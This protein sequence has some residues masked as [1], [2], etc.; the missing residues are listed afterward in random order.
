MLTLSAPRRRLGNRTAD[1]KF[2]KTTTFRRRAH[3][4]LAEL[5]AERGCLVSEFPLCTPPLKYHFPQ[6]NRL[7]AG[8]ARAVLVV[9][10]PEKSGALITAHYALD[11]GKEI[12][13]VPGPIHN[14]IDRWRAH[15]KPAV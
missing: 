6:R 5:M 4:D 12:F 14:Q 1:P 15:R 9:E 10:A 2:I 3:E 7:I 11:E 8:L 13:A